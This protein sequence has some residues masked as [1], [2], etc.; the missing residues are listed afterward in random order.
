MPET[1]SAD[2]N[3]V[4]WM[5]QSDS[6]LDFVGRFLNVKKHQQDQAKQELQGAMSLSQA[7]FPVDPKIFSKLVKKSGLPIATDEKTLQAFHSSMS[8]EKQKAQTGE[9]GQGTKGGGSPT[10]GTPPSI[11][12]PDG[13]PQYVKEVAEAHNKIASTGKP[14]DGGEEMGLY[15]NVL[16]GR[17][18]QMMNTKASTEQQRA[19]NELHVEDLKSKGLSGDNTARG[20]LMRMGEIKVDTDFEKW[21][22]MTDQQKTGMFDVIAGNE[23]RAELAQRSTKIAEGLLSSGKITNLK[24]AFRAGKILAEG[25]NL[26]ADIKVKSADFNELA[27]QSV[28]AGRLVELGVPTDKIAQTMKVAEA[29]GLENAL[30]T[31]LKPIALQAL[32]MDK[33]KMAIEKLR[34]EKELEIAKKMTAAEARKAITDEQKAQLE[35]FKSLAALKQAGG[36]VSDDVIKGAEAKAAKALDLDVKEVDT[37]W[38]FITGGTKMEYKPKV[39]PESKQAIDELTGGS[40]DEETDT[41]EEGVSK[42]VGKSRD[43]E[44]PT[45]GEK[46]FAGFVQGLV[47]GKKRKPGI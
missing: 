9:Q 26:P 3:S 1:P 17:A 13:S 28:L 11:Q 5:S 24:D 33:D 14:L 20:A 37:F 25:G 35:E 46:G 16:A 45:P 40:D 18:R 44:E 41:P 43:E 10:A 6:V 47:G 29:A 34:Y 12:A 2:N 19:E 42:K 4:S 21:T 32:Q 7:G 23:S 36:K 15:M 39:T 31:G 8:E 22:A 30:P 27:N 38:H